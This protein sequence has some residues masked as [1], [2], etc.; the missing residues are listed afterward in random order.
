MIK[1]NNCVF[2]LV[3]SS[4][5][6]TGCDFFN[7]KP[8]SS[9]GDTLDEN[10]SIDTSNIDTSSSNNTSVTSEEDVTVPDGYIDRDLNTL[11][12]TNRQLPIGNY[13]DYVE[14]I[15]SSKNSKPTSELAAFEKTNNGQVKGVYQ[16]TYQAGLEKLFDY[17]VKTKINISI[18]KQELEMLEYDYEVDNHETYRMCNLDI[19]YEGLHFHFLQVGIRQKGNMSRGE[20]INGDGVNLR[21]YKL[22]FEE[23][24]DDE[25]RTDKA[26]W[27][28]SSAKAYREDRKFF[29]TS[30]LNLRWNRNEDSTYAREAYASA[31]YRE[32]GVPAAKTSVMNFVMT[33]DGHELSHGVYMVT[34]QI[35]KSF[36][37]RN[38]VKAARNGDLYKLTWGFSGEGASFSTNTL[39]HIGVSSQTW[40]GSRFEQNKKAYD[41]KTNKSSSNHEN[42]K[43]FINDIA[44]VRGKDS[45]TFFS[46]RS[47][48]DEF[49]S[50]LA[51]SFLMGDPDDL[52]GNS[53]NSYVYFIGGSNK[54]V[55][56][57]TDMDRVMGATGNTG[58]G[59]PTGNHGASIGLYDQRTG[60]NNSSDLFGKTLVS[61]NS[62]TIREA[63]KNRV[64]KIVDDGW[65]DI[66]HYQT[67]FDAFKNNYQNDVALS[68][69]VIGGYKTFSLS[70]G[71]DLG[72]DYNL[73]ISKYFSEKK[74][75]IN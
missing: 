49:Y 28:R 43:S 10:S 64:N 57:P 54:I 48:I 15:D 59:N 44:P 23:T 4:L 24:F 16:T 45:Y 69:K 29:G 73:S 72:G 31:L 36:I 53:N 21:H 34:E 19:F 37:K 60:Y 38:F 75:H 20:I 46:E 65:L 58:G 41:L 47:D 6:L 56:I 52:R 55:F 5:V 7:I 42:L 51:C 66:D 11:K 9:S 18:S 40:N 14:F 61:S 17:R 35:D 39:S 67:Y 62:T 25:Y 33:V 68:D 22:S 50:F 8:S 70:E 3:L 12:L 27:Y 63:Y 30:K 74:N 1:K 26:N 71:N 32:Y 13:G 2:L